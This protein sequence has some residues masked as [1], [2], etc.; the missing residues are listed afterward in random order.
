MESVT[1]Q[2]ETQQPAY[3]D[4]TYE[5]VSKVAYLIGVPDHIF[6]RENEPPKL[7]VYTRLEKDK[8]ARIIRNLCILRTIIERNF[9]KLNDIM[10]FEYRGL[11]S[12]TEIIPYECVRQLAEDG[13]FCF[14]SQNKSLCQYVVELNRTISDRINNCKGLFPLWVNWTYIRALF[15]MPGGFTEEGTKSAAEVYYSARTFYPYQ[16]YINWTPSDEGNILYN[17]KKFITLLY[18]W[19]ND[20]FR[21][22]N[23]VSDAGSFVKNNIYDFVAESQKT[24]IVVDCENSDPYKLCATLTNLNSDVMMRISAIFLFDDVHTAPAWRVLEAYTDIPVEHIMIERIKQNKSL[25]DIKLTA[26]ACREHFVNGVDSFVIVS[27]DSDYWGLISSLPDARFLVML[28]HEKCGPDMKAALAD[29]GIFYCYLDDFYAANSES[30]KRQ[31][32]FAE[33]ERWIYNCVHLNVNDMLDTALRNTRIIMT[34]A[35]KNQFYERYI[36][37]MT[38]TIDENGD[39]QLKLKRK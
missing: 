2:N 5:L 11:L 28:E 21:E 3:K 33:M 22:F 13:I 15:I 9:K 17:D 4:A 10:R 25:V 26:R 29:S 24:V 38:L 34:P 31:V 20:T 1:V 12:I 6:Q 36:K 32:L 37:Q 19:N 16:M 18:K 30:I 23:K 7:E 39:V 14:R 27:S 8:N 35:E